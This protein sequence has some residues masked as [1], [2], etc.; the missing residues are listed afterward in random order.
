[1]LNGPAKDDHQLLEWLQQEFPDE[2]F[3]MDDIVETYQTSFE[4]EEK[5]IIFE[6]L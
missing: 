1:M 2:K 4:I 6:M 5:E 3:T